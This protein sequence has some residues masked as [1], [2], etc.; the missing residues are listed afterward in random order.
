MNGVLQPEHSTRK[1]LDLTSKRMSVSS[2]S[3]QNG[4]IVASTAAFLQAM[5]TSAAL[6]V[7]FLPQTVQTSLIR[8]F[9]QTRPESSLW[10]QR[11]TVRPL[12]GC[13][14]SQKSYCQ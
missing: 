7:V 6:E 4:L 11:G 5:Q 1:R 13:K 2:R 8:P 14:T 12:L 9:K 3:R 10:G